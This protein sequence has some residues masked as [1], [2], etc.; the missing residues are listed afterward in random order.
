[1]VNQFINQSINY[2]PQNNFHQFINQSINY[3]PQNNFQLPVIPPRTTPTDEDKPQLPHPPRK[4]P[5]DYLV[6]RDN[7][8][9]DGTKYAM[10]R[11]DHPTDEDGEPLPT[12]PPRHRT[13]LKNIKQSSIPAQF[14]PPLHNL[15]YRKCSL[16]EERL[17]VNRR[18]L[19]NFNSRLDSTSE[20]S[21]SSPALDKKPN[22]G[23]ICMSSKGKN[24]LEP[25][26]SI[27][28]FCFIRA[29]NNY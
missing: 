25:G 3:I 26:F 1:M 11:F 29:T 20:M 23:Y 28:N 2:I 13:V 17:R 14:N 22:H 21:E 19:Q 9:G 10:N 8:E 4:H 6:L 7:D 16:P 27:F 5:N 18:L 12:R 15:N 24:W